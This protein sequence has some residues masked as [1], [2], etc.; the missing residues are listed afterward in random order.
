[1]NRRS[2]R[3]KLR[4][5]QKIAL[6]FSLL[7]LVVYYVHDLEPNWIEVRSVSLSLPHLAPEF[8]GYRVVQL[9]DIHADRRMTA[10]RIQKIVDRVNRMNPDLVV[11]TGDFVTRNP[12]KY[13]PNLMSLKALKPTDKTLAILGNHDAW[14]DP[15]LIQTT[16]ETAGVDVLSNQVVTLN[17][18]L[19]QL[20]IG[21]VDDVWAKRDRLNKVLD[22]LPSTGAAILLAH[23][24][25]F[26]DTSAA[27]GRF[28]LQLSGH[29]H[30]G[31]IYIPFMKRV[32]PPLAYKYPLGQYQVGS[33]I[34]YTNRGLGSSGIPIRFN[35][36]PE[37]TVFTL[38]SA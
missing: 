34:Q 23:E 14:T 21:G 20:H 19:A 38:K 12:Q 7:L 26:A 27:T 9:S 8:A 17:R 25:D 2:R 5:Y 33:M 22:A 15:D 10:Q 16:L 36:R 32:L 31:Q 29:S 18:T 3:F 6:A 30:G 11:L 28:D 13:A 1:M 37:I 4:L 24:P 35:C